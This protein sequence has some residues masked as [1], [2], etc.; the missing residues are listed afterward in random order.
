MDFDVELMA[1]TSERISESLSEQ[2]KSLTQTHGVDFSMSVMGNVGCY[3]LTCLIAS[4]EDEGA[5]MIKLLMLVKVLSVNVRAEIASIETDEIIEK[6]K[7]DSK[8]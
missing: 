3:L 5:R 6:I 2:M 1:E 7:K 8:C 4:E